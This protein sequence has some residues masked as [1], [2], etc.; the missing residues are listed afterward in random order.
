MALQFA[1]HLSYK[2]WLHTSKT[3]FSVMIFII[4][5]LISH[6]NLSRKF[7]I[8]L[9]SWGIFI[10]LFLIFKW[11]M[12]WCIPDT[13]IIKV[14]WA[15]Y[16]M[17]AK[18][19]TYLRSIFLHLKVDQFCSFFAVMFYVNMVG[20]LWCVSQETS[21]NLL[22]IAWLNKFSCTSKKFILAF[23]DSMD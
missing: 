7:Q 21:P 11:V 20:S 13:Y 5:E 2:T 16:C 3:P 18:P 12:P 19:Y 10:I 4:Q 6:L 14:F 22:Q 17:R 1:S 15:L 9:W 23:H 8:L